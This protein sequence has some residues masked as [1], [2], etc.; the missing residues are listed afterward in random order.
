MTNQQ[1]AE[2]LVAKLS[3]QIEHRMAE[4]KESYSEAKAKVAE[5]SV[6]GPAVWQIL[7]SKFN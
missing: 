4:M 2:I 1:I 6:A 7:D 5:S 3:R